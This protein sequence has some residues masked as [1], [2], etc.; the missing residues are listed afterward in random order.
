MNQ[1]CFFQP[2]SSS[3]STVFIPAS[4]VLGGVPPGRPLDGAYGQPLCPGSMEYP[5]Q[6]NYP[7]GPRG[8]G[9]Y[10]PHPAVA[11]DLGCGSLAS[12]SAYGSPGG[13]LSPYG[14]SDPYGAGPPG[15]PPRH[16]RHG[17]RQRDPRAQRSLPLQQLF[18][19]GRGK[20]H[21]YEL[22]QP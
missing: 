14:S 21:S 10:N 2:V 8:N 19:P 1:E 6:Q 22:G 18:D 9:Y 17:L 7:V 3:S 20:A 13:Y 4:A 16:H 11:D 15:P 5:S 12:T